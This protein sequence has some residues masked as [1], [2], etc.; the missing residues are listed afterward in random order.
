MNQETFTCE[1]CG[2]SFPMSQVG[3]AMNLGRGPEYS[4]LGC[5]PPATADEGKRTIEAFVNAKKD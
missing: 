5:K 4:C 2:G 3:L 1:E